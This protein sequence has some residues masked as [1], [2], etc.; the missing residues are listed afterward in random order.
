MDNRLYA[1]ALSR[2][3]NPS[4]AIRLTSIGAATQRVGLNVDQLQVLPSLDSLH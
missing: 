2:V 1:D 3:V 4:S